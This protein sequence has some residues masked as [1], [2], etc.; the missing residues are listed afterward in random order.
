MMTGL[1]AAFTVVLFGAAFFWPGASLAHEEKKF[2]HDLDRLEKKPEGMI[3]YDPKKVPPSGQEGLVPPAAAPADKESDHG[4]MDHGAMSHDDA[5]RTRGA[6]DLAGKA[7]AGESAQTL[8]ARGKN[9]YLHMCVFC[10]G[11]DGNGGGK[12]TDYLYPWPRD[13]R[14]GIFKF[15]STPTGTLPRDEDL[16]RTIVAGVPG[17]AMPAW[18][19][20]LSPE[21]TWALVNLIKSFSPRFRKEAP[22]GKIK[23]TEPPASSPELVARGNELY[24][25]NKCFRCH[26]DSGVGDGELSDSLIDA[27]KHSVFIHDIT[28]PIYIKAGSSPKDL[29]RTLSSGLDGTPMEAFSHLPEKD[30]WA[31]VH[32]IRSRFKKEQKPAET[33][34]DVY[35]YRVKAPLNTEVDNPIWKGVK[36]TVIMMRPLSARRGAVET[37]K[38]ASV[39]NGEKIAIRLEWEDATKNEFVETQQDFFRD[40]AAVQFALG[41]VTLHTHGHNEPFF[42]MGNRG[43]AV[44]I[45]HWRAGLSEQLTSQ[46]ELEYSTGGVDMDALVYGGLMLNPVAKLNT[47]QENAVDE[48][49]AEGFGSLTPQ[50]PE[51]Q[52]VDGY[53]RWKNGV[54]TVVFLRDLKSNNKYDV[55]LKDRSGPA[56]LALAAWDGIKEDRNGRKVI[57]VWQRLSILNR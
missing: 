7:P 50:P 4:A 20:A 45:W 33:E 36:S 5:F 9:I 25:A 32:F 29:F 11:E 34:T 2:S 15:R 27:W 8:L 38:F 35:S 6:H 51:M 1:G 41:D 37:I 12:A 54:W 3:E 31:L 28:N 52:N 24:K 16:Y 42:G 18:G 30:R 21:D 39:N 14:L 22:G 26:G 53:G 55:E 19:P 43:K 10:H 23:F 40:G 13:F 48:L 44:N 46:N 47:T 56:L 57:S 49:N 17:T